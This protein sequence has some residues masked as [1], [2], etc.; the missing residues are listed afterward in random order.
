MAERNARSALIAK[1]KK[2]FPRKKCLHSRCPVL[3]AYP[4]IEYILN[5]EHYI[6]KAREWS[7]TNPAK[8]LAK[9]QRRRA[10]IAGVRN[11]LT[12]AEWQEIKAR[13]GYRC[14]YC[15]R[16]VN[17]LTQD[18]VIPLSRGGEHAVTNIVPAC[19]KC[20]CSKGT[21]PPPSPVQTVLFA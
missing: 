18:H 16:R 7:K 15:H 8:A 10:R 13:F 21:K 3:R 12:L 6:Q 17:V 14:A 11:T 9:K 5:R 4:K 20:N 1:N 2:R 19:R